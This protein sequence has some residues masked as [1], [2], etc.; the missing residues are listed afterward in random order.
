MNENIL[1]V[2]DEKDIRESLSSVLQT[3][4]YICTEAED[5]EKAIEKLETS[6]YDIVISDIVMPKLDGM[7]FLEKSLQISPDTVIV[8]MTAYAS[9][10]TAVSAL[11]KGAADYLLKPI[12][13]DEVIMRV[14]QLLKQKQLILENKL[15]KQQIEKRFDFNNII[16]QSQSMQDIYAMIKQISTAPTNVLITGASGT[17]KELIA[18]AIHKN[19][20]RFEQPFIP[21]NC[22]AIP[23]NLYESE[24]FGYK[25]G[26]F[27]GANT[28]RDGLFKAANTGTIFLDEVG[29][30][31]ESVQVKLL[32]VLQEKEIR[33][34]GS[35]TIIKI[36]VRI[37]AATNKDLY[38]EVQGKKFREDLYYR[39]NV[40]EL[41]LPT[42]TERKED[43]PLLVSHFI[44]R[45]NEELNK[46]IKGVDN[47]VMRTFLQYEWK[48]NLRE[49]EN[50]IER[51][52]LLCETEYI[53]IKALPPYMQ[54]NNKKSDN[55]NNLPDN[56]TEALEVVEKQ[57]ITKILKEFDWNRVET[58]QKLGIDTSTLYRKM[59]KLSI[60]PD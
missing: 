20:N 9:I 27:T 19:S 45:F 52:V 3:E 29:E 23:E 57:H 30:L 60:K 58:S 43:I 34:V 24:L 17:G 7:K 37:L 35:N 31:P 48:G 41:K 59:I 2:D 15:L 28:D 25:K 22:G 14:K 40:I 54:G 50:M 5:G 46:K 36:D 33:P 44:Q 49:L 53:T 51:A 8:L 47:E 1:I 13:F 55:F 42:L 39:L 16:G 6:N 38:N 32:R 12:E 11:R 56:L 18:R 4:G 26:S 10:E 21:V